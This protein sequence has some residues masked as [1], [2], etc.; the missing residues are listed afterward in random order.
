[1]KPRVYLDTAL[2][3]PKLVEALAAGTR[4]VL[5]VAATT[6]VAG[7]AGRPWAPGIIGHEFGSR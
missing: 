5:S 7:I 3:G 1:M 2:T 6:A 4:Q